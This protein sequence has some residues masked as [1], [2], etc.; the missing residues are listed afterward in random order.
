MIQHTSLYIHVYNRYTYIKGKDAG[1][2]T[3]MVRRALKESG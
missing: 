1:L 3:L 2:E